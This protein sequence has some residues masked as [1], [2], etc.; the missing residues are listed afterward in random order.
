MTS[1][2]RLLF[3]AWVLAV[4]AGCQQATQISYS[5]EGAFE[6]S[7]L[8]FEHAFTDAGAADAARRAR[9]QCAQRK[10][11]AVETNRACTLTRCTTHF[12]CM[13]PA[14]AAKYQTVK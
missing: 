2:L 14:D 8:S 1:I 4:S 10:R 3:F 11:L 7:H 5:Q 13:D 12:Q 6:R 9:D